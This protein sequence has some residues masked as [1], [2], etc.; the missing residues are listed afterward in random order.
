MG[1]LK[2]CEGAVWDAW[3]CVEGPVWGPWRCLEVC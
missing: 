3:R 1:C 2:V